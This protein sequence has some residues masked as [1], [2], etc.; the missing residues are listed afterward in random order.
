MTRENVW[1]RLRPLIGT[2]LTTV[3]MAGTAA[4]AQDAAPAVTWSSST[5]GEGAPEQVAPGYTEFQ[6]DD[7]GDSGY[8]LTVFR[9][10][11][12]VTLEQ[13]EAANAALDAAFGGGGDPTEAL[14]AA[15]ELADA[16]AEV[17]AAPGQSA[18]V[19]AVLEEGDYVLYGSPHGEGPPERTYR[20]F[21]VD[22][23]PQAEAPEADVTVQMVDFA[24]ALPPDIGPGEQTWHVL[25]AGQQLHHMVVFRLNEG[26]TMDDVMSFV[27]T[28]EGPP[29]GEQAAYVGIMSDDRGVYQTVDLVP[30]EY[31]ALCFM[32]D[33]LG[34]ATGMPHVML[35]MAQAFTV[36]AD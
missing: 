17:D 2:V 25:N 11:E 5:A 15:L 6:I 31:V 34:D 7:D 33:H 13:F 29:P 18:T 21:T 30:G 28:E 8:T 4:S 27:E 23:E 20:T 19:G 24:F 1:G 36:A 3:L 9:L 26:A 32:P 14:N 16:V 35:G 12:G 10:E 22:G